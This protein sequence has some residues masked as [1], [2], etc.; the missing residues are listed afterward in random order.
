MKYEIIF[1]EFKGLFPECKEKFDALEAN[2]ALDGEGDEMP[3][4]AYGLVVM[5]FIYE[6]LRNND[7]ARLVKSF[8]FFEDM[9]KA[10]DDRIQDLL[11]FTI[12][13]NLCT[14]SKEIYEASKKYIGPETKAFVNQVATYMDIETMD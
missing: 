13:E 6:L 5:P 3:H 2:T 4:V 8:G 14:E 9:A 12:L 10:S 1:T 11:Q 7:E